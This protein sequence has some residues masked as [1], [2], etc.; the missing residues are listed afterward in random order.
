MRNCQPQRGAAILTA[1]LTVALVA[2]LA[3][4]AFWRQW[5]SIEVALSQRQQLQAQWLMTGALDWA[6][7][8]VG[9][10]GVRNPAL[11]HL[12]EAWAQPVRGASLQ[13]FLSQRSASADRPAAPSPPGPDEARLDLEITDA[14]GR[15]NLLNLLEGQTVSAPWLAVFGRLFGQLDLPPEQLAWLA[16]QLRRAYLGTDSAD[17][18]L[19]APLIPLRQADLAWLGLAPDTVQALLPHVSLLPGRVPVNLNTAP[20]QV[21]QAVLGLPAADVQQLVARRQA[22][23]FAH[24]AAL[25]LKTPDP[26]MLA[27]N[28]YFF[29]VRVRLRLGGGAPLALRENALLQRDGLDVR[30]LWQ[31][32]EMPDVL[33]P[34]ASAPTRP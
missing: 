10:D 28:S 25:G 9:E 29:E 21:L 20:T 31:R 8:Q 27:V 12:G 7:A 4:A 26:Q 32:R 30:T 24:L 19:I 23:P 33:A 6:R 5:R 1:L 14:Q 13:E 3:V 34:S 11:D 22:Q 15:L 17:P 16:E 2:G 18:G